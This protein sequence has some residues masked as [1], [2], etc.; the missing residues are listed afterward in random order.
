META[1]LFFAAGSALGFFSVAF[2][3]FGAHALKNHLDSYFLS[4]FKTG[5]EYQFYH[6]L[7]LLALGVLSSMGSSAFVKWSGICFIV[8]TVFFSG[9][10]YLL[11]LSRVK[12]WGAVTPMGGVFFL[13]GWLLL[14]V[15]SL[16]GALR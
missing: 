1:K 9:S 11:A 13:V 10:L 15:G 2:G 12:M 4:V 8:G 5:V 16:R 6:A 3:A 7:A 14:L